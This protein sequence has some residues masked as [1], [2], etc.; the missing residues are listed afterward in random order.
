[1]PPGSASV[2][3]DPEVEISPS[4]REPSTLRVG[5]AERDACVSTLIEHHLHGR[6]SVEELDRRQRQAMAAVTTR[7][8]DTLLA[9]LPPGEAPAVRSFHRVLTTGAPGPLANAAIRF[10]PVSVMVGG[11]AAFSQWAWQYSAEGP[12]LGALAGG[13]V[14]YATGALMGRSRR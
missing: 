3:H 7:D 13:V 5:D 11:C 6:L 4:G 8:L 12:F 9:D 2:C 10:L 14:G 1:M